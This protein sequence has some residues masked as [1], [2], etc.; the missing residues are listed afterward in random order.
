MT[1]HEQYLSNSGLHGPL[2]ICHICKKPVIRA[3]SQRDEL[4][5]GTRFRVYCHG[6]VE[7]FL[8]GDEFARFFMDRFNVEVGEAF[9]PKG[10]ALIDRVPEI[11]RAKIKVLSSQGL[12]RSFVGKIIIVDE[13]KGE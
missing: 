6:D 3:E 2:P 13:I 10:V 1:D 4:L 11:Q 12:D 9:L 5:R 8:L 7:E